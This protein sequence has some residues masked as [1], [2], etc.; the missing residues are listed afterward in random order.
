MERAMMPCDSRRE[1]HH[2]GTA[3]NPELERI[4]SKHTIL[5]STGCTRDFCQSGR[6][7]HTDEPRGTCVPKVSL[8][9]QMPEVG[10]QHTMLEDNSFGTLFRPMR[11]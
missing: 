2:A 1:E 5:A 11:S 6:M 3:L 9:F 7:T 8:P 4:R 10:I